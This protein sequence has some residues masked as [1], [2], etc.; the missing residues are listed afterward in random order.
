MKGYLVIDSFYLLTNCWYQGN[1][2]FSGDDARTSRWPV[3]IY[4]F[5]HDDLL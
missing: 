5:C 4:E 3:G 1:Q 2:L